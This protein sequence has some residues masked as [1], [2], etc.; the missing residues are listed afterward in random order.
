MLTTD[1]EYKKGYYTGREAAIICFGFCIIT[2]PSVFSYT[3]SIA[4]LDVG[5]FSYFF[6]TLIIVGVISTIILSRIPP[7]TWIPNTYYND[8]P[9]ETAVVGKEDGKTAF[10]RAYEK[11]ASAPGIVEM[12]K[13]GLMKSLRLYMNVFPLIILL[14][15]IVLVLTEYTPVFSII[16]TP[17]VPVLGHLGIPEADLVA[18]ALLTG[19]ADLLLPFLAATGIQ[20]QLSK[21]IVCIVG[22]IQVICMS[23]T[24]TVLLKTEIPVKFRDLVIVFLEKTVLAVIIALIMGRLIGLT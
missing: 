16:A 8:T 5:T 23:E 2:F 11:A 13:M 1:E 24:G 18:P 19:F 9:N 14:A 17:L 20:S 4:G 10:D 12:L 22:T 21:F 7:I 6:L 15:T 3:T